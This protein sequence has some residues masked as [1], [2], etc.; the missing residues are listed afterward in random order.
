MSRSL[1][2]VVAVSLSIST[3]AFAK[4]SK[5]AGKSAGGGSVGCM[6]TALAGES[7][8]T[9]S[10]M[11]AV[12]RTIMRRVQLGEG[13]ICSIVYA[14]LQFVGVRIAH[15]KPASWW[16]LAKSVASKVVS[17]NLTHPYRQ[18]RTAGYARGVHK[19]GNV[20]FDTGKGGSVR[21]ASSRRHSGRQ[22]A[23]HSHGRMVAEFY[24]NNDGFSNFFDGS[25]AR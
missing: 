19:G 15:S 3:S 7:N 1:L 13:S 24:P 5:K 18:F 2:L 20:F 25:A 9:A 8:G 11:E 22:Y 4:T 10:S 23:R 14:P 21:Y 12:G 16:A 6:A 17:N